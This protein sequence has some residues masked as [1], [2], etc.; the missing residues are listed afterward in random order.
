MIEKRS[1]VERLDE[2]LSVPGL[3]LVQWGPS[4][5]AMSIGRP[6]ETDSKQVRDAERLVLE[7]CR[8]AG[9]P[10][11]AEI[12]SLEEARRYLD[13][14]VRHFCIGSDLHIVYEFLRREGEGL[15]ALIGA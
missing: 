15:R 5:Y 2:I 3:D 1:A 6:G 4:D 13:L 9:V 7:T 12:D 11:R 14:G 10:A 8:A